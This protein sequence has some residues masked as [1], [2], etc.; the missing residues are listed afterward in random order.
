MSEA[1]GN[2]DGNPDIW[3]ERF[4]I[5][6]FTSR[7]ID[8]KDS[9]SGRFK[10]SR[11]RNFTSRIYDLKDPGSRILHPY[12][13]FKDS[14]SRIF[15]S[16]QKGRYRTFFLYSGRVFWSKRT[17]PYLFSLF[18]TCILVKKYGTVPFF[19]IRDVYSGQKVRYRTFFLYS[20]WCICLCFYLTTGTRHF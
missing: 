10:R 5:R 19:F 14:G 20:Y 16:G 1:P 4:R 13:R 3:F 12:L 2:W 6:Y 7:I 11:I 9:G 17:V 15:Q 18:G 8:I